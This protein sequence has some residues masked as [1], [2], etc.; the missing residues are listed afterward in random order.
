MKLNS[1][2]ASKWGM[3]FIAI[4][5]LTLFAGT[6][7]VSS[8]KG[9]NGSG[10]KGNKGGGSPQSV[11]VTFMGPHL[12]GAPQP[13]RGT[14][15]VDAVDV[16]GDYTMSLNLD[17]A[18][19][20]CPEQPTGNIVWE[21]GLV[22]F[23]QNNTPATGKLDLFLNKD[24][25]FSGQGDVDSWTTK[26]GDFDYVFQMFRWSSH[27]ITESVEGTTFIEY[28]G[29]S[30]EVFKKKRGKMISR[31]QCFGNYMDYDVLVQ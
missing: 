23:V 16:S 9:G 29:A 19:L 1:K 11:V 5:I 28:R 25:S 22:A 27:D 20:S 13:I 21:S 7:I 31:E 30:V 17:L 15:T 3:S 26:I 2:T 10:G 4:V 24:G 8:G 14:S 12:N 6:Q 18:N